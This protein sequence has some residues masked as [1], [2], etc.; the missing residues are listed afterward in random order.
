MTQMH[1]V[2]RAMDLLLPKLDRC[3]YCNDAVTQ[4]EPQGSSGRI[5]WHTACYNEAAEAI[6]LMEDEGFDFYAPDRYDSD[7]DRDFEDLG[8]AA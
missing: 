1:A 2:S 8:D 6:R 7:D 3:L 4:D 5:H